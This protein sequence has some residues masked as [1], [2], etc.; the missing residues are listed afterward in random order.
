M[1]CLMSFQSKSDIRQDLSFELSDR[2][3]FGPSREPLQVN[4]V[5]LEA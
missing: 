4:L 2:W 1:M 5:G 3:I